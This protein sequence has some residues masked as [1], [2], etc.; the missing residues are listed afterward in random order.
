MSAVGTYYVMYLD[1]ETIFR[2]ILLWSSV[3]LTFQGI[4]TLAWMTY[5]WNDPDIGK[6]SKSPERY[7]SPHYSFTALVP[8]RN[9][10]MVVLD[11]IKAINAI[12]YPDELK[13]IIV[14]VRHDDKKTVAQAQKALNIIGKPNISLY[15]LGDT[16]PIN[17]PLSLNMGIRQSKHQVIAIFDAEDEPSSEIYQIVNTVLFNDQVDVV[18]SGVQLM[19][20]NSSW[21]STLNV[22][23]YFLWFKSGMHFFVNVGN[24]AM[25]GGNTVFIK[26]DF[27]NNLNG[28][29]ETALTEDADVGIRLTLSGAK[30]K[31]IYDE[32]HVTKEETPATVQDFI[33]QRTR[34]NHGFLQIISKG[35]WLG[36]P[37]VKQ[38]LL[39][40]YVLLA[41]FFPLMMF[42]Y[43]PIGLLSTFVLPSSVILAMI[44]YAPFYILVA[45]YSMQVVALWEFTRIYNLKFYWYMPFKIMFTFIPYTSLLA[46]SSLRSIT[47]FVFGFN[48]WEKTTH[49][50]LHRSS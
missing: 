42:I 5:A 37:G 45:L 29:D 14:I 22:L 10:E 24:V 4:V 21:F 1:V 36:L 30:T 50:N 34:W 13:E 6:S 19:N 46:Y 44:T 47:R 8:M 23:E 20:Y 2:T 40:L 18:Q 17:K 26:K 43:I 41:P 31:I 15:I 25:L 28:W 27:L 3:F 12:N 39:S 49:L 9:E 32:K 16:Y 7:I 35:D 38:K 48:A 33:K 11:T